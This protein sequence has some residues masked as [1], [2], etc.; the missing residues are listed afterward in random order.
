MIQGGLN[1]KTFRKSNL[2]FH[3]NDIQIYHRP[4]TS[5]W[6]TNKIVLEKFIEGIKKRKEHQANNDLDMKY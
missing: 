6:K 2:L 1:L 5:K 3:F 4:D